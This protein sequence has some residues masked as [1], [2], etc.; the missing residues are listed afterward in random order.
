[1]SASPPAIDDELAERLETLMA[2]GAREEAVRIAARL[3][4]ADLARPMNYLSAGE[5]ETLFGWL[6]GE[7]AGLALTD[8]DEELRAQL[9]EETHSERLKVFQRRRRPA[10]SRCPARRLCL[11][12]LAAAHATARPQAPA[13]RPTRAA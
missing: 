4:P 1:M 2:A 9:L 3:H 5:R 6:P 7:Q 12:P 11:A 8:L 10:A 13:R